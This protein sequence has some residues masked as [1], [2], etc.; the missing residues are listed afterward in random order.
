MN[1]QQ[2]DYT[3]QRIKYIANEKKFECECA[4]PSLVKHIRQSI[5]A[6]TAK[7]KTSAAIIE[8]FR[9]ALMTDRYSCDSGKI[10]DLFVPPQSYVDQCKELEAEKA[11]HANENAMTM[12]FA[13]GLIDRIELGEFED[14][15]EPIRLMEAYTPKKPTK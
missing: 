2:R 9:D 12:K 10:T 5:A 13:Q 3:I 14:G 6:G 8:H 4:E 15:K 7:L 11:K 1:K